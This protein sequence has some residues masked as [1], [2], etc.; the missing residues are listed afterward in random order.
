LVF[1]C[2]TVVQCVLAQQP[3]SILTKASA[4]PAIAVDSSILSNNKIRTGAQTGPVLVFPDSAAIV[5]TKKESFFHRNF[6]KKYPNPRVAALLSFVLPGAGQAYNKKWWK[7]P[8]VYG[9]LGGMTWLALDNDKEYQKL[10]KNY[11]LLVD[12]DDN[13]NPTEAPYI[14]MSAPQMKGY[15]DQFRGYTE[16]SYLFLGITYLLAVTDAFVDA[17]LSQFDVSD[18]LSLRLA[19]D[20]QSASGGFGASFGVGI[21]L[22]FGRAPNGAL[23]VKNGFVAP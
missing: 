20:I 17:H 18:D 13:T 7:I 3:D 15:R 22:G 2:C 21:Q 6:V 5:R 16:K 10:K 12:G 23:N 11:K 14:Y 19:P 9:A 8:I 1:L 4:V